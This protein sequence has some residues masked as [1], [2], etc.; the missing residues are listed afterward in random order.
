FRGVAG[1][2]PP[3]DPWSLKEALAPHM[4]A[5][6]TQAS[7]RLACAEALAAGITS[8][9]NWGHN[10]TGPEEADA[11]LRGLVGS[12]IR[13]R[14]APG[15]PSTKWGLSLAE[16][17]AVMAGVGRRVNEPMDIPDL[18]RI[19]RDW[20]DGAA[21]DDRIRLGVSLR[22]PARSTPEV[23]EQEFR[24]ARDLGVPIYMHCAGTLAEVGRIRQVEV[25]DGLSL[26]GPDLRL[27]HG[28]HLSSTDIQLMA[29][30]GVAL[31]ITPI[32]ELRLELGMAPLTEL[33]QAGILVSL[34]FDNPAY[35]AAMDMFVTMR[36]TLG[37]ERTRQGRVEAIG[38]RD[39][40]E[41]ATIDGARYL[42][43]DDVAGSLTPGKRADIVLVRRDDLNLAPAGRPADAL[44]FSAA[45]GNV[46]TVIAD[47]RLL[48]VAGQLT[49]CDPVGIAHE[50]DA[51]LRRI[52][53]RAG[54]TDLLSA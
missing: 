22:G 7:V 9:I 29:D 5:E 31:A 33:R 43:L 34:G 49:A 16:M 3:R 15:A 48:K 36:V 54:A 44:V 27:A 4:T 51:A 1:D 17:D 42:G 53:Q 2:Q 24:A 45:P 11:N 41:M 38:P 39:V 19:K 20:F 50:A 37:L 47:G 40:L 14:Y 13:A 23:V 18:A 10:W 8:V 21:V 25:L 28:M 46:D 12:G 35:A 6:D 30:N 32:S 52:C 26:L